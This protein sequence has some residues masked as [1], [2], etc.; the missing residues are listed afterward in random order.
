MTQLF[1]DHLLLLF[2]DIFNCKIL[3]EDISSKKITFNVEDDEWKD[4]KSE[5]IISIGDI[6]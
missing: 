2:L 1:D 6:L 5:K 4:T 3:K